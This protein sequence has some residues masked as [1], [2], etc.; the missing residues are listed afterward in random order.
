M[1]KKLL[2]VLAVVFILLQ[3]CTTQGVDLTGDSVPIQRTTK[4]SALL[5]FNRDAYAFNK[6]IDNGVVKP[7]AKGYKQVTPEFVDTG[8]SNAF[9]NLA[10]VP[11]AV[12]AL[13]Q[14][15]PKNAA[16]DAG[17]FLINS[18]IGLAGF[19]DVATKMKLEKHHEDFGQTLAKWGM[20][21][22]EYI[23][24]PVLGPSTARDSV[25]IVV[26]SITNP[27]FFFENSLAYYALDKI[28]Q[29]AALLSSEGLLSELSDNEY[30]SMRDVWLQ[31]RKYLINDGKL[32]T[33]AVKKKKSLIDELEDLD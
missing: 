2:I 23:M 10:D 27:Y 20:P 24:L 16:S 7:L 14:F 12:N 9:S 15:K 19:F 25:G 31:K 22:G 32:D 3:A 11:N 8:I 30:N 17:R 29:R 5:A 33:Q 26:D 18:S 28:D 21:S 1:S 4:S 13:L 6:S